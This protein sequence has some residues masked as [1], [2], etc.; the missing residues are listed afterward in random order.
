MEAEE[1]ELVAQEEPQLL[2]LAGGGRTAEVPQEGSLEAPQQ[3]EQ[4]EANVFH[5]LPITKTEDDFIKSVDTER[6]H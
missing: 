5:F 4:V 3:A 2:E 1:D 6:H